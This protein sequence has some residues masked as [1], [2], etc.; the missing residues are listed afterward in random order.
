[1]Q[2]AVQ[3]EVWVGHAELQ[4]SVGLLPLSLSSQEHSA[5]KASDSRERLVALR[6]LVTS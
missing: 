3:M 1:M 6:P 5:T 2:V 4:L